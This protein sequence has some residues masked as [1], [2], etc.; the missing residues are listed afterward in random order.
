VFD[1]VVI[2]AGPAGMEAAH[3]AGELGASTALV[4]KDYLGGMGTNDGPVPVRTLA[5]AARLMREAQQLGRY[6]I[7]IPT[8]RFDYQRLLSRV[9][10]VVE[11]VDRALNNREFLGSLGITIYEHAGYAQFI[12]AHTIIT[13]KGIRIQGDKFIICA[14]GKSRMLPIP[15]IENTYTHT[16]AWSLTEIPA[17]MAVI[18]AGATGVQVASIFHAFGSQVSLFEVA[19][20]ILMVEDVEVS[21]AMAAAYRADGMMVVEGFDGISRIESLEPGYRLFYKLHGREHTLDTDLV[22]MAVGWIANA[23]ALN[24]PAAGVETNAQ[25]YIPVNE[26]MQT[27]ASHIFAAGDIN[28]QAMLVPSAIQEGYHAASNAVEGLKYPLIYDL[29]PTGSFTNP[30]YASVGMTEKKAR[31]TYDCVV[32]TVRFDEFPRS[33]IDGN[34]RGFCHTNFWARM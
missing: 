30:E 18:G 21:R 10:T 22:V 29:I 33:I 3:R 17:S 2:G 14:G 12:D 15:G 4:T 19:P 11:E 24:L 13:E 31:K 25:G 8:P 1:V 23:D 7:V 6:G 26:Y 16:D 34:T 27:T 9:Q 32:G 5:H 20:R 28:G